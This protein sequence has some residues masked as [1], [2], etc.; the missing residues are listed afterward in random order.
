MFTAG[1]PRMNV[2]N[3]DPSTLFE[4]LKL[5]Q[6]RSLDV[7]AGLS[8]DQL[9]HAL[10]PTKVPNPVATT[11]LEAIDWNIKHTMWHCGQIGLL[12][13]VVDKRLDFGL[14]PG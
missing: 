9:E 6:G 1:D 8:E 12:K 5:V 7:I 2:G 14:R 11:K 13:R 10:E 3:V 4:Q